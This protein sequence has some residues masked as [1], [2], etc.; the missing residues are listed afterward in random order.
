MKLGDRAKSAA[1]GVKMKMAS[2]DKPIRIELFLVN[3]AGDLQLRSSG[4]LC[5][6][7]PRRRPR[8]VPND[9]ACRHPS[10]HAN[11]EH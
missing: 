6:I 11:E 1:V 4:G 7:A 9:V 2:A 5:D 8:D 3:E 10:D